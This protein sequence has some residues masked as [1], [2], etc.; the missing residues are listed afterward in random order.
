MTMSWMT[1]AVLCGMALSS[2]QI[3]RAAERQPVAAPKPKSAIERKTVAELIDDL[4]N[5]KYAVRQ[6]AT[7]ELVSRRRKAM[8]ALIA[9]AKGT[10]LESAAR[11][12]MILERLYSDLSLSEEDV[13]KVATTLEDLRKTGKAS[14]SQLAANALARNT[15]LRE[16]RAIAAIKRLGGIVEY[17][18]YSTPTQPGVPIQPRQPAGKS[19]QINFVLLG[20]NWR[21]GDEGLKYLERIEDLPNL[22]IAKNKAFSPVSQ[23]ALEKFAASRPNMRV[24]ERGLSCLGVSG[25]Q[26]VG[27]VGCYVSLVKKDSAAAKGG[28]HAGDYITSFGGKDVSD[29][30]G[31]VKLIAQYKPG[32]KVPVTVRRAGHEVKLTV[33]LQEWAP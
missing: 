26:N 13:V 29:F 8:P 32:K 31:L 28:M 5:G 24:H 2:A 3:V 18:R 23:K 15:D 6:A 11:A 22:Y 21:G 4:G 10:D 12:V 30:E 25:Y 14:V 16:R 27:G 33:E 9:T 7:R 17:M 20:S 19:T 1:R